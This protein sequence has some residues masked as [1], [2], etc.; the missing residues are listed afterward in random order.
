MAKK[1]AKVVYE[2]DRFDTLVIVWPIG[3]TMLE[4]C[5]KGEYVL[6]PDGEGMKWE[7]AALIKKFPVKGGINHDNF[8]DE[9][10]KIF[11]SVGSMF[12]EARE[13]VAADEW[14]DD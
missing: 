11:E 6:G 2:D 12:E 8:E 10:H 5:H 1:S 14:Y 4:L 3:A 13:P 9:A 7:P